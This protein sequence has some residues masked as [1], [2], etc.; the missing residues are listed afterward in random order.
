M[1]SEKFNEWIE[2]CNLIRIKH[3]L[4]DGLTIEQI[5]KDKIGI[6]KTTF[7]RWLAKSQELKK[8]VEEGKMPANEIVE[9]AVFKHAVVFFVVEEKIEPDGSVTKYRKFIKGNVGAMVLWLKNRN[10]ERWKDKWD[11]ELNY[12]TPLVIIDEA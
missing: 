3:W 11:I 12:D 6:N 2:E 1:V 10:R 9:N 7:Y 4:R 5:T 8:A